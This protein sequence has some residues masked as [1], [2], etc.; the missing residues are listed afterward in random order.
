MLYYLQ[1]ST[2]GIKEEDNS[3]YTC[4]IDNFN[5]YLHVIKICYFLHGIFRI[6]YGTFV[7]DTLSLKVAYVGI[8][9]SKRNTIS[10]ANLLTKYY[11]CGVAKNHRV[12][13]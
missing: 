1:S 11:Y 2:K 10:H 6:L 12:K 3:E 9:R 5:S 7:K 13:D 8:H 4:S